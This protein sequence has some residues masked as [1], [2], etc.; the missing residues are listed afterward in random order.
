MVGFESWFSHTAV[1]HVTARPFATH[2]T[3]QHFDNSFCD[4]QTAHP[5]QFYVQSSISYSSVNRNNMVEF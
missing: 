1:R 5:R 2:T 4:V 3:L